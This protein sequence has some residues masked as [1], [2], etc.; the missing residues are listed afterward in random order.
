MSRSIRRPFFIITALIIGAFSILSASVANAAEVVRIYSSRHYD[1]DQKL[2]DLFTQQTGIKVEHTSA[3]A[4]E[5]LA[6]LQQEGARSPADILISV[7][8][9]NLWRAKEAG[10]LAPV[11]SAVLTQAI[12]STLRD[13]GNEWFGVSKRARVIIY[14]KAVVD[15]AKLTRY[16]DLANPEWQGRVVL[17]PSSNVY[18]QSLTAS[19]LAN[20]GAEKTQA[21]V[22]GMMRN[23]K[24]PPAG[25]DVELI[26]EVGLGNA[27]V[28]IANT[29]YYARMLQSPNPEMVKA[30][31]GVGIV[32]PNQNDR[33]T[34]VNISGIG[35]TKSGKNKAAAIKFM[36]FLVSPEAQE[37]FA[38][39]NNEYPVVAEVAENST[40]QRLGQFKE[41]TLN[42]SV[43]GK[44]TVE[45]IKIMDRG[46]WK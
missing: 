29:Y 20:D 9:G 22:A 5:L 35:L 45:A 42:L 32:F 27:D 1:V 37:I 24:K 2:Y 19:M 26:R 39:A 16:E 13:P 14:N 8:V 41:D 33:G 17:R 11:E 10:V 18:N 23:L 43:I 28:T 40:V 12:P 21:W 25:N 7:D 4:T 3:G 31:Q 44:N 34:H 46:G 38:A 36:E 6:R 30:A 15:P